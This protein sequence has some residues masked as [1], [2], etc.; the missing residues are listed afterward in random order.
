MSTHEE[1]ERLRRAVTRLAEAQQ[2]ALE[3][4]DQALEVGRAFEAGEAGL[5]D[6]AQ[7]LEESQHLEAA[8]E[9]VR[10]ILDSALV[11]VQAILGGDGR[12]GGA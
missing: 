6:D 9:D 1:L 4:T 12:G 5:E 2:E 7:L 8:L 11:D 3:V 10:A